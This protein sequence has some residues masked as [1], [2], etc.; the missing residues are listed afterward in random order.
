M[1]PIRLVAA[2]LALLITVAARADNVPLS[3][4]HDGK[5]T[6]GT[7]ATLA[8]FRIHYGNTAALDRLIDVPNGTLR[9]YVVTGLVPATWQFAITAYDTAGRESDPS[10]IATREVL[11]PPPSP[12][13][14]APGVLVA[15]GRS[16]FVIKQT[17]DRVSVV[18]AG[19]VPSD[20]RCIPSNGLFVDG[21]I[22]Y[23]VPAAAVT[24]AGSVKSVVVLADCS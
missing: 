19:T 10:G 7:P 16:V 4:T 9:A 20:T 11:A 8:G 24:W 14:S 3:W 6:D 2:L 22:Y 13:P 23:R 12:L 17:A 1:K 15:A 5:N 18:P 21:K